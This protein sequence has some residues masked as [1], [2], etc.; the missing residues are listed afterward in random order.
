M[1]ST[2]FLDSRQPL[3]Y[4]SHSG[5]APGRVIHS[6]EECVIVIVTAMVDPLV[7]MEGMMNLANID[8]PSLSVARMS[9]YL[10]CIVA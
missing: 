2:R 3:Q 9:Y 7:G 10:E 6:G 8:C 1:C 4:V 5:F